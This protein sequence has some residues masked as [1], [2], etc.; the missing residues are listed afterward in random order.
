MRSTFRFFCG[1]VATAAVIFGFFYRPQNEINNRQ[2]TTW[3]LSLL[4]AGI[5]LLGLLWVGK[6]PFTR[7]RGLD[8]EDRLRHSVQRVS[9]VLMVG[10]ILISLQ[11][12]R[13]Q[14][15]IANEIEKPFD[16]VNSRG[17]EVLI[18][19]PRLINQA[20]ANQRPCSLATAAWKASTTTT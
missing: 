2:D 8:P 19:D 5:A 12:L 15:V 10:F 11:L 13:Q 14:V 4:V 20:L 7:K 16:A 18:Q 3:L 6:A 9:S 1:L 17:K